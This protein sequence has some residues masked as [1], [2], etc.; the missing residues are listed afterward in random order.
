MSA[1]DFNS[2]QGFVTAFIDVPLNQAPV[3]AALIE[4]A[5]LSSNPLIQAGTAD[6][7]LAQQSFGTTAQTYT[8]TLNQAQL[9]ALATYI[10]NGGDFAFGFDADCHF[11]NNG[12]RFSFTTAPTAAPEPATMV[13]LGVGLAGFGYY[14]RKRYRRHSGRRG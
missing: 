12:I 10:A 9:A 7:L 14:Q 11:W 4:D 3:P 1:A 2:G 6:T 8:L 5:F 13:L